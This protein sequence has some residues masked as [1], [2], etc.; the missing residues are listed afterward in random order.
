MRMAWILLS[1]AAL[2]VTGCGGKE[3]EQ[4]AEIERPRAAALSCTAIKGEIEANN[5]EIV[6]LSGEATLAVAET[7]MAGIGGPYV[8]PLWETVEIRSARGKTLANRN[9]ELAEIYQMLCLPAASTAVAVDAGPRPYEG[10]PLTAFT[11]QQIDA[12]CREPW[13]MQTDPDTGRTLYNP[14][15]MPE[16]FS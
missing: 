12:Y 1:L 8:W 14:C 10:T 16:A 11:K 13:E 15:R 9:R 6:A 3:P 5:R 4:G 7:V 2:S